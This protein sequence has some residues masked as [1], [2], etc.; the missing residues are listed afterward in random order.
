[1]RNFTRIQACISEPK[2]QY[3]KKTAISTSQSEMEVQLQSDIHPRRWQFLG[4]WGG[5]DHVPM[6]L[7]FLLAIHTA[8]LAR[9]QYTL[10][11]LRHQPS[12]CLVQTHGGMGPNSSQSLLLSGLRLLHRLLWDWLG[13]HC[14]LHRLLHRHRKEYGEYTAS[15]EV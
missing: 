6:Y 7:R 1:M 3:P 2:Q 11:A 14:L 15:G 4:I 8:R 10:Q 12:H 9:R 13:G 5:R